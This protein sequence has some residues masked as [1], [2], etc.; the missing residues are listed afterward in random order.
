MSIIR[1]LLRWLVLGWDRLTH[2]ARPK[3]APEVQAELDRQT[4]DLAIYQYEAC[5]FC[6]KTRREVT[7]LGL[8]VEYRDARRDEVHRRALLEGGGKE[9]VPCLRIA[10]A[11]GAATWMYESDDIIR[12]LNERFAPQL[13]TASK[14]GD[15]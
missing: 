7:R 1:W 12:Y 14:A 8:N 10:E 15:A 11:D 3:H 5:P 2:P 4:R 13:R 9:Q 6:V